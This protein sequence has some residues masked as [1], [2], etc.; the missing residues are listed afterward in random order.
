MKLTKTYLYTLC[1]G[2]FYQFNVY[3]ITDAA[4]QVYYM[5]TPLGHGG[6]K[7]ADTEEELKKKLEALVPII[8]DFLSKVR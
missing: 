4:H 1:V 6:T 5:G 7:T 3:R 8:N 2:D